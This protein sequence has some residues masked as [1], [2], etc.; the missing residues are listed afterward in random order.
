MAEE[1]P[2][3]VNLSY[4][5]KPSAQTPHCGPYGTGATGALYIDGSVF[6]GIR[7]GSRGG[8]LRSRGAEGGV[9]CCTCSV[10][11][12]AETA[13]TAVSVDW[14]DDAW[15]T[16]LRAW[17]ASAAL[18]NAPTPPLGTFV[19]NP[20]WSVI[21]FWP[22]ALDGQNIPCACAGAPNPTK[23]TGATTPSHSGRKRNG[24]P[25]FASP[26]SST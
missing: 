18:E 5:P 17:L 19:Q 15:V 2:S 22:A 25:N 6:V 24:V 20:L 8:N 11:R 23:A 12:R 10:L 21:P 1:T 16:S 3:P 13:W 4:S 14:A 9:S 26:A 7:P